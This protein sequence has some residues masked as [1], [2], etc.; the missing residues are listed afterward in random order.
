MQLKSFLSA[1]ITVLWDFIGL[2][3]IATICNFKSKAQHEMLKKAKDHHISADFLIICLQTLAKEICHEFCIEWK[4]ENTCIPTYKDLKTYFKPGSTWI[5]DVNLARI[6]TIVNGPLLSTF[7]L[8]VGT[9][10]SNAALY[11]GAMSECL[12]LLYHNKNSNYGVHCM[13][14]TMRAKWS[15]EGIGRRPESHIRSAKGGSI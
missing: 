14:H 11:Y 8:R 2:E 15:L 13:T 6:F 4:K 10:C 9:R 3:K 5:F 7:M 1:A 12:S